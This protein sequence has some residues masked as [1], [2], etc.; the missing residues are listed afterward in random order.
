VLYRGYTFKA[1]LPEPQTNAGLDRNGDIIEH[2]CIVMNRNPNDDD[3]LYVYMTSQVSKTKSYYDRVDPEGYV[4]LSIDFM[5]TYFPDDPK[6]TI[7]KC[8][9]GDIQEINKDL[10]IHKI[11]NRIFEK[12]P[13]VPEEVLNNIELAMLDSVTYSNDPNSKYRKMI[14][15]IFFRTF[16]SSPQSMTKF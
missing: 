15:S 12:V 6:E 4:E 14:T 11:A 5:R 7:I 2:T 9:A 16:L 10:L 13:D 1:P 3:S 8:G